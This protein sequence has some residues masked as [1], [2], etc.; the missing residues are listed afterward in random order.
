MRARIVEY[1]LRPTV[2]RCWN[3]A[4]MGRTISVT[5]ERSTGADPRW[6]FRREPG[7][8]LIAD[9]EDVTGPDDALE[10]ARAVASASAR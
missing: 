2:L 7:E 8:R 4:E 9:A 10:A 1:T 5:C 3:P 6:Q